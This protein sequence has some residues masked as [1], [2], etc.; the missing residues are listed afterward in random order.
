MITARRPMRVLRIAF[1]AFVTMHP[2][3]ACAQDLGPARGLD[4]HLGRL[5]FGLLLCLALAIGAAFLLK[6]ASK[7][8]LRPR[9]QLGGW[10]RGVATDIN[11][12]ETKRL[13]VHADICRLSHGGREYLVIVSPGAATVLRENAI[14]ESPQ[15]P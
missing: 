9:P 13:S 4:L 10:L 14:G 1:C 7:Q 11:I 8:S 12:H 3:L 5:I 6:R 2:A 15:P